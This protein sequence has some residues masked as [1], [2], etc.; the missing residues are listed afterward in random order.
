MGSTTVS[1][2]WQCPMLWT[3]VSVLAS[4]PRAS[5]SAVMDNLHQ[6]MSKLFIGVMV[7]LCLY[8]V[9]KIIYERRTAI[10]EFDLR[11]NIEERERKIGQ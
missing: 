9:G 5:K 7:L 10:M 1:Q 3:W 6:K 4:S 2:R 11:R 8:F